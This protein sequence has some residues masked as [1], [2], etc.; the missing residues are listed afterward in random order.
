M[1]NPA[2]VLTKS[3]PWANL[4]VFVEPLLF[5]KGDPSEADR[6][7]GTSTEGSDEGPRPDQVAPSATEG[8]APSRGETRPTTRD[9]GETSLHEQTGLRG[10]QAGASVLWN[11]MYAALADHD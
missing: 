11:N 5:W 10:E 9:V 3:L 6:A 1:E 4:R 7:T 2:D 8:R